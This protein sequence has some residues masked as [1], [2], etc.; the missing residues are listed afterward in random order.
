MFFQFS[1]TGDHYDQLPENK[2]QPITPE[3]SSQQPFR[4]PS[5]TDN[6]ETEKQ[7]TKSEKIITF[8]NLSSHSNNHS[9]K[10]SSKLTKNLANRKSAFFRR[11][12]HSLTNVWQKTLN[13]TTVMSTAAAP[14]LGTNT[15]RIDLGTDGTMEYGNGTDQQKLGMATTPGSVAQLPMGD[16]AAGGGDKTGA[17]AA[18]PAPPKRPVRRG[19]KPQ[20]DRPVRALFCLGLKNPLRKLCIDIVEWKPFEYLILLTIFANC[21]ALAVYTPYPNSDSNQTNAYLEKIEYIFLIIFTAEC[22]MKIIAYG[23]VLHQGAY[24]RNGW[25]LLDFTIVVIG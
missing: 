15:L 24:L 25:N 13:A 5:D 4:G 10:S 8:A 11:R 12:R 9:E 18:Q 3:S 20:P 14:Q 2:A 19:V 7:S 22:F 6:T 16:N 23:F 21:V 1:F 17:A